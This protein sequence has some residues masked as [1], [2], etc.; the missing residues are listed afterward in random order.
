MKLTIVVLA[1]LF[2]LAH[3]NP[4]PAESIDLVNIPL[5]NNKELDILTLAENDGTIN[6]RN[7]RTIGIL[8]E[9]FPQLSKLL[10]Q[11]LQMLI[12]FV[13]RTI[14]PILLRGGLGGGA[15]GATTSRSNIDDDFDDFDDDDNEVDDKKKDDDKVNI[16]LPTFKPDTDVS[17]LT[18]SVTPK[19]E[20]PRINL[21]DDNLSTSTQTSL[22]TEDD[23][24]SLR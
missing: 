10:E 8:R 22:T 24:F 13:V 16:S 4:L 6:E 23:D 17:I 18:T 7:K 9:L 5:S 11:K 14:G 3:S 20:P 1:A 15:T 19:T 12:Q 2:C 21:L